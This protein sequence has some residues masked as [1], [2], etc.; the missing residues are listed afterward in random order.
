[1]ANENDGAIAVGIIVFTLA[2]VALG[3]MYIL[4]WGNRGSESPK[5][6]SGAATAGVSFTPPPEVQAYLDAQKE[7]DPRKSADL[8]TLKKLL[9]KRAMADIPIIFS[10]EREGQSIDRLYK[11]GM[12]TDDIHFKTQFQK[13]FVDQ[14]LKEIKEEADELCEGWG[15]K[16]W[17]QSVQFYHLMQKKIQEEQGKVVD[18]DDDDDVEEV[19]GEEDGV[20]VDRGDGMEGDDSDKPSKKQ[21]GQKKPQSSKKTEITENLDHL[22]PSERA[23]RMA[24]LLKDEEENEKKKKAQKK[25][26]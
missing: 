11:R 22:S 16:I 26:K 9:I 21:S 12:L 17:P 23:E 2:L 20:L 6:K 8:D 10:L 3:G 25:K 19:D 7:L 5:K 14:E 4:F 1:M 18:D 15:D 13:A 24:K